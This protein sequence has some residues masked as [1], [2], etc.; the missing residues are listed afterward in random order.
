MWW[1]ERLSMPRH[2]IHVGRQKATAIRHDGRSTE[3]LSECPLDGLDISTPEGMAPRLIDMAKLITGKPKWVLLMDSCWLPVTTFDTLVQPW[4]PAEIKELA[5]HR[6]E[7]LYGREHGPWSSQTNYLPGDTAA[8]V[9]GVSARVRS[10]LMEFSEQTKGRVASI[11]PA[12]L[13]AW[14][15]T[16]RVNGMRRLPGNWL[17]CEQDRCIATTSLKGHLQ[18]VMST[19]QVPSSLADVEGLLKHGNALGPA[20]IVLMGMTPPPWAQQLPPEGWITSAGV[21]VTGRWLL[22]PSLQKE[23]A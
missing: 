12:L 4:M 5:R 14:Q 11:L 16:A 22:G 8:T 20:P 23:A 13:W 9:Y 18:V 10:Q 3:A 2:F 19:A 6:W 15:E 1:P 21:R 17:W 7:S